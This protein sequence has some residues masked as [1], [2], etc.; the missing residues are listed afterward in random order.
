MLLLPS[1]FNSNNIIHFYQYLIIW[2]LPYSI[3]VIEKPL[4]ERGRPFTLCNKDG[5]GLGNGDPLYGVEAWSCSCSYGM[6]SSHSCTAISI[7]WAFWLVWRNF[8]VRGTLSQEN[9]HIDSKVQNI[10]TDTNSVFKTS[11]RGEYDKNELI[12]L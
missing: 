1:Y 10:N 6:P 5:T 8:R 7:Y 9:K 4:F 11:I 3:A 2:S 12:A